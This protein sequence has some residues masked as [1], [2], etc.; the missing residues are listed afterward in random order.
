MTGE[1]AAGSDDLLL[2]TICR[3]D[4]VL[5]NESPDFVKIVCRLRG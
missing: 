1:P 2:D 4:A 3:I 5:C